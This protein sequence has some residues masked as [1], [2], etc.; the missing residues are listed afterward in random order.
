MASGSEVLPVGRR[1]RSLQHLDLFLVKDF[2]ERGYVDYESQVVVNCFELEKLEPANTVVCSIPA[3]DH[4]KK[5][6]KT[7]KTLLG[8]F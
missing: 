4:T 6:M 7:T 2:F 3:A 5:K 1:V 8:F